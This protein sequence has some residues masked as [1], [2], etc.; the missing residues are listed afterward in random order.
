LRGLAN[1]DL[2]ES[3]DKVDFSTSVVMWHLITHIC[4]LLLAANSKDG[5]GGGGRDHM[6]LAMEVSNY[7]MDLVLVRRVLISSE[8]HVAH[9]KAREEVKQIL[10]EHGKKV[11][12]DDAEAVREVLEA[13]VGVRKKVD[14]DDVSKVPEAGVGVRADDAEAIIEVLEAGVGVRRD[15][16]ERDVE[17]GKEVDAEAVVSEVLEAGA[18]ERDAAPEGAYWQFARDKYETI[19]PVL[20]RA[21]SLA[22]MLL[23]GQDTETGGGDGDRVWELIA[24]VWIEMLFHLATRCEAGFHAKNLCTGGEFI[25]HVRFLLL[26]RGIGWDFVLGRA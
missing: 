12:A 19:R 4:S 15:P 18:G 9:R 14:A 5:G 3:I 16:A 7:L 11:D 10:A 6:L 23:N 2:Y 24:S 8:G 21:W 26:N 17:H 20:P 22:R 25:T 1:S 13:V